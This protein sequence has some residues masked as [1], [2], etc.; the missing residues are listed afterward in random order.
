MRDLFNK[1]IPNLW[2]I[3]WVAV[4]TALSVGSAIWSIKWLLNLIGVV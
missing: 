3:C 4:I 1:I 2:G